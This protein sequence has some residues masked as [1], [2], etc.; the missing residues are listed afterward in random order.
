MTSLGGKDGA[1]DGD[2]GGLG[3]HVGGAE[4]GGYPDVLDDC[5]E[6]HEGLGVGDGRERVGAW[7]GRGRP[8]RAREEGDM[9]SLVARDVLQTVA[10]LSEKNRQSGCSEIHNRSRERTQSG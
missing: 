6:A 10:D 2:V 9:L 5:G 1:C 8:E 4:V 7:L 3:D